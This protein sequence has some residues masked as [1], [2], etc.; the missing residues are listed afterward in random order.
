MSRANSPGHG[1]GVASTALAIG[2]QIWYPLIHGHG[3]VV[4]TIVS[5][6]AFFVASL[7]HAARRGWRAAVALVVVC[8]GAGFAAEAIGIRTGWPFGRYH[9]N[10][11]L[12]LQ[13]LAVPV[14]VPMAWAMV[15]WP[16][17][18]AARRAG[19][20]VVGPLLFVTW[21][22][23]LD[24]QMVGDGHW[25]WLP[26]RWPKVHG[27]PV[28]NALGWFA[29]G[30]VL[31]VVLDRLVPNRASDATTIAALPSVLLGWT[32][33]SQTLGNIVFF[34]RPT[35]GVTGG[36]AMGAVLLS[37]FRPARAVRSPSPVAAVT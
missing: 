23:F 13:L 15:G 2:S 7:T 36:V 35:V 12:G 22:L 10:H 24:P 3:R 4:C 5:V 30:A 18:L 29:V 17:L 6:I 9:Y 27:I 26:T 37:V 20:L 32:W 16:F 11:T 21:D 34:H 33:F 28:S 1:I 8:C 31:T 14:V 19:R 25:R